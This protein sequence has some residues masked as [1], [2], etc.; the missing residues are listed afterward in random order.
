[1]F[2]EKPMQKPLL[3]EISS[4]ESPLYEKS[5][6]KPFNPDDL[7]QKKGDYSI[8]DEMRE[9]DQVKAVLVTQ[10]QLMLNSGWEFHIEEHDDKQ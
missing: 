4:S 3:M 1:M 2:K 6:F 7:Y 8:Y 10:K 9:D 5:Q